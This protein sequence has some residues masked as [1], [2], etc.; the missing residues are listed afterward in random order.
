MDDFD[1]EEQ[2]FPGVHTNKT[3]DCLSFMVIQVKWF[4]RSVT[5]TKCLM[6]IIEF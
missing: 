5:Q 3:E 1:F 2:C 4:V 6:F